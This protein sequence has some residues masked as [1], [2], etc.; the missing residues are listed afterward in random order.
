MHT[1]TKH[2]TTCENQQNPATTGTRVSH[3]YNSV[4]LHHSQSMSSMK[5]GRQRRAELYGH[6][7]GQANKSADTALTATKQKVIESKD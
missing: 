6:G 3:N 5:E 1:T 7:Q 4:P 2:P